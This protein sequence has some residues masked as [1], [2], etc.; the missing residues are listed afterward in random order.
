MS[1]LPHNSSI[2]IDPQQLA[3]LGVDD[4]PAHVDE[5]VPENN[6][7]QQPDPSLESY[8]ITTSSRGEE[9]VISELASMTLDKKPF[10][11]KDMLMR[12]KR[13]EEMGPATEKLETMY[14]QLPFKRARLV[15]KEVMRERGPAANE[16]DVYDGA[17]EDGMS[18]LLYRHIDSKMSQVLVRSRGPN[19]T[20]KQAEVKAKR[21]ANK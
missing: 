17:E 12:N 13:P 6:N 16:I 14:H 8:T 11:Y 1:E 19:L 20:Q 15:V 3:T 4:T 18:D 9:M 7:D 21:I 2:E 5:E 10:S